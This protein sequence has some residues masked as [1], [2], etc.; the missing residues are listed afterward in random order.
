MGTTQDVKDRIPGLQFRLSSKTNKST[1]TMAGT[2]HGTIELACE[3]KDKKMFDAAA[4]KLDGF[5]MFGELSEE[6]VDALGEELDNTAQTLAQAQREIVELKA[7]VDAR[8]AEITRLRG[9]LQVIEDDL[10][11]SRG[12]AV[13]NDRD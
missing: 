9:L 13:C 12:E 5:K 3:F 1:P 10:E 7:V 8:D 2:F 4:E 11:D 6:I